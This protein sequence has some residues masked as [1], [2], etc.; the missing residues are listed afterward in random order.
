MDEEIGTPPWIDKSNGTLEKLKLSQAPPHDDLVLSIELVS[1]RGNVSFSLILEADGPKLIAGTEAASDVTI[2]L[3][4]NVA[5]DLHLGS[6]SVAEAISA[7]EIKLKGRV[8]RLLQAGDA[9][10]YIA[11]ALSNILE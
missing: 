3:D 7:G 2:S 4:Q 11:K 9:L 5:R 8:D 1:E 10:S 6:V